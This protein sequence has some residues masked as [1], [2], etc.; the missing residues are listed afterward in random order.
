M[1]EAIIVSLY[2]GKGPRDNCS[3]YRPIS[4]LSVPG[5]V[6]AHVLLARIHPLLIKNRRPQQS[7]FTAGRSTVDAILALRLLAELHRA[8]N[9]PLHVAYIDVK[10]AFD[11]VDRS[12]LW[13]V[14]QAEG[15]PPSLLQLIRNLHTGTT[16]RVRTH[17][18]L[19]ASFNTASGV[20]Q[21]CILAPDLFCSAIDWLMEMLS[22][23][24][25]DS[26]GIEVAGSHF[27]DM[28]YADDAVLLT[29]DPRNWGNVLG[30]YED[31]ASTVGLHTNWLKTKIQN[32]GAGL[33]PETVSMYGQTV[34]PVV[35]FTYLG[36]DVDSEGYSTPEIH[37]RLGMG[38]S[39]MG[40]LD[41]S[42]RQQK[43]SLQTKLRLYTSLVLSVVLYGSETWTLRKSDSDRLQSFHMTSQRRIPWHQM[44]RTRD[45][46]LHSGDNRPDELITHHCRPTSRHVRPRLSSAPG[47]S[48]SASLATVH[49]HL[50]R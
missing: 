9:W 29:S 2:K 8:F 41:A 48:C 38:N 30:C 43:L 26:F 50:Q 14:L 42:W 27:T 33:A 25:P 28:D 22:H 34:E 32:I 1:K 18:G 19:S 23:L 13:K 49:R 11:S 12:A 24:C 16:A 31:S 21:G 35:K 36:S 4:L 37:R 47:N 44:V 40:Q 17:N 15:M 10:S 6:F 5:K 46:R 39:I 3:N 20:R 45:K 7:G